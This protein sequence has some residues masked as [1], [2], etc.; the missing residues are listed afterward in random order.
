[1]PLEKCCEIQG[2][3]SAWSKT[4]QDV[5]AMLAKTFHMNAQD[6]SAAHSWWLSQLTADLARFPR[7]NELCEHYEKQYMGAAPA[8]P[9]SDLSF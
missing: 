2:A 1:M 4:G 9:D 8:A 3:M 5:N 6:F 7:Y